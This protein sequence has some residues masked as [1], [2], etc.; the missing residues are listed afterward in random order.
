MKIKYSNK[1]SWQLFQ[2]KVFVINEV[3]HKQYTFDGIYKWFW[4]Q[5][6][7]EILLENIVKKIH[8]SVVEVDYHEI[9]MDYQ[10]YVN[11]LKKE[12]LLEELR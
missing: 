12:G 8:L 6:K 1:I 9:L 5:L 7:D 3:T 2:D 10:V 4:L 11:K